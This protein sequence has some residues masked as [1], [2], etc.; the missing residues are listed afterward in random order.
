MDFQIQGPKKVSIEKI[1]KVCVQAQIERLCQG[2][3][4]QLEFHQS[5]VMFLGELQQ[6]DDEV[7][8]ALRALKADWIR[9]SAPYTRVVSLQR[10]H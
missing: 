9:K 8:G 1:A 5:G 10:I 6:L 4:D 3:A 7:E 2:G